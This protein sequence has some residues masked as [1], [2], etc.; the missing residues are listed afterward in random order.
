M[1]EA[2]R[3]RGSSGSLPHSQPPTAAGQPNVGERVGRKRVRERRPRFREE[4]EDELRRRGMHAE[5]EIVLEHHRRCFS[6]PGLGIDDPVRE[7]AL[8]DLWVYYA[9]LPDDVIW[10]TPASRPRVDRVGA[11]H[12]SRVEKATDVGDE[13]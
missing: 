3:R 4:L 6:G 12:P 11:L 5:L 2:A 10:E 1:N 8:L 13:R 9:S 7:A